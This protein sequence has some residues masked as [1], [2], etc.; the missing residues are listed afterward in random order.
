MSNF[1]VQSQQ[2]EELAN[3]T[4]AE[5]QAKIRARYPEA[6]VTEIGDMVV[7][8][9]KDSAAGVDDFIRLDVLT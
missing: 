7:V 3:K 6:E 1:V 9:A 4:W 5:V 8:T 2:A